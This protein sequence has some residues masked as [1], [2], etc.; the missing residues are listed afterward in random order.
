MVFA[1]ACS[2]SEKSGPPADPCAA[3]GLPSTFRFETGSVDGHADPFG[4]I[5]AEG[6]HAGG[7]GADLAGKGFVAQFG[8]AVTQRA[9][10]G[11]PQGGF[12]DELVKKGGGVHGSVRARGCSLNEAV[13]VSEPVRRN[14]EK[15]PDGAYSAS[16]ARRRRTGRD[17][18]DMP[19]CR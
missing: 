3:A 5:Q 4:A 6:H 13:S 17:A 7:K 19:I 9:G 15:L 11:R 2:S 1:L 16:G 12:G 18:S 10:I 8:G 14:C